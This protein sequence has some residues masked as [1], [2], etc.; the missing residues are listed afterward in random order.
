MAT[1]PDFLAVGHVSKD[2]LPAGD[3]SVGGTV[4]YAALTARAL[5]LSAAVLTSAPP[6]MELSRALP[7]IGLQVVPSDVATT[8]EN[9]YDGARRHQ[10]VHGVARPL[11][12]SDL[13]VAWQRTP[14]VLLGPLVGELGLDWLGRSAP[15]GVRP[16]RGALSAVVVGVTPQGWMRRW[17]GDGRV[18]SKPWAEAGQILPAVDVLV[19]SE[20]DVA[21]D[22]AI[23]R[24]YAALARLAVVT[25]GRHGATVFRDGVVRDFPAFRARE[26]DPTGAGDV[27]ATAFLVR[28]HETGD[29]YQA[30]RFANCTASFA[31]EGPGTT[32]IPTRSQVEERLLRGEFY[33]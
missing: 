13:P 29:P 6:D 16:E 3:Y 28:L 32:S 31:I 17:D 10:Y 11:H 24:Q 25:R 14:I 19:F 4:T 21:G 33:E 9:I 2:I 15:A 20:D 1:N 7:G 26:V 27:F 23:V 5:G 12:A 30:A 8:F 18:S 22:E